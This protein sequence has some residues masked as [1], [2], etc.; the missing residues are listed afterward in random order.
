[1]QAISFGPLQGNWIRVEFC[2]HKETRSALY[3]RAVLAERSRISMSFAQRLKEARKEKGCSQEQLAETLEVSRQSITKW[4]TGTAY[5][6]LKKLLGLSVFLDK[7]LDELFCD[8][9]DELTEHGETAERL[10]KSSGQI[11][12]ERSLRKARLNRLINRIVGA[13]EG[14]EF[15]EIIEEEK[16][17][18]EKDYFIFETAVY[19]RC[20]GF[21][22]LTGEEISTFVKMDKG[23]VLDFLVTEA[24]KIREQLL[25]V[26]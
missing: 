11:S 2:F 13:L 14:V 9:L 17:Q 19:E 3:R 4:E 1:M 12:D 7:N 16:F 8:E 22:P 15:R 10:G 20:C 24:Q 23:Q 26:S 21:N 6:E 5:P 25:R 18:G